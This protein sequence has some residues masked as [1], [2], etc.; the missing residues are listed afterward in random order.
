MVWDQHEAEHRVPKRVLA[1]QPPVICEALES[2][3]NVDAGKKCSW[4]R[5]FLKWFEHTVSLGW[6]VG[7]GPPPHTQEVPAWKKNPV[8]LSGWP[9]SSPMAPWT[10]K[11]G[12][13]GRV[14]AHN[15][16]H[17]ADTNPQE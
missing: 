11:G 1:L 5:F 12:A 13:E 14:P 17:K 3:S 16:A 8:P 9:R 15:E 10:L 6:L 4:Q 2:D 7:G